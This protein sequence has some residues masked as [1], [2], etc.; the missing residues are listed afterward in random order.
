MNKIKSLIKNSPWVIAVIYVVIGVIWIQFSDQIVL[1]LFDDSETITQIQSIKGW[2][3][4]F[5]SGLLIFL[6]VKIS[7]ELLV[8]VINDLRVSNK[9]FKATIENAPLGIAH[10]KPNEKWIEVNQA[11][12]DLLGYERE[13][14]MQLNFSDFIHPDDLEKGREMDQKLISGE[15]RRSQNE[16]RY[17]RKDGTIFTGMVHKS[18]VFNGRS[19]PSYLVVVLKDITRQKEQG[20][21]I[22]QSLKEKEMLLSEIH[23]RVR[24]NLAL[25]SAFF[26]LE[27]LYTDNQQVHRILDKNKKRIKCLALIHESFAGSER[28]A[29]IRFGSL[30]DELT[31]YLHS[32]FSQEGHISEIRKTI[33]PVQ[34]NINQAIPVS[35]IITELLIGVQNEFN[36]HLKSSL[37]ELS[38]KEEDNDIILMLSVNGM[39]NR[40]GSQKKSVIS[41]TEILSSTILQALVTQISGDLKS[42][43]YGSGIE[44]SLLFEKN[45]NRGPGSS[46]PAENESNGISGNSE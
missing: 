42:R 2:F 17:I 37:L 18:A 46:L 30:L 27:N 33:S 1:T 15:V 40:N 9:K 36:S 5:A 35:L 24:N 13:Q 19:E 23:H 16:K 10:H 12:C 28:L 41:N 3:F 14:L 25:I 44:Y 43:T 22:L 11:L 8:G 6:L 38:L 4:V 20:N 39:K 31:D 45:E 29:D 32:T 34:L 7:N 21:L 26:D